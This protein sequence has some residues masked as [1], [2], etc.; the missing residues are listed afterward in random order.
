MP[1]PV[2]VTI[3]LKTAGIALRAVR[4]LEPADRSWAALPSEVGA[5]RAY[6]ELV[7]A[8]EELEGAIKE[9]GDG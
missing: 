5:R 4:Y 1:S 8:R 6:I 7:A 2:S 9:C 3:S